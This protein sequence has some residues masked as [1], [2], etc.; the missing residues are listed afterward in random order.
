MQ[1]HDTNPAAIVA[2]AEPLA[3]VN[4]GA[5]DAPDH[6]A[7]E[8]VPDTFLA[9]RYAVARQT[10]WRWAQEGK[11]PQPVKLTRG[12]TRWRLSEVVGMLEG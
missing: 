2:T 9:H 5:K 10:I 4:P 7:P 3:P 6:F 12:C 8:W 1:A 11:L